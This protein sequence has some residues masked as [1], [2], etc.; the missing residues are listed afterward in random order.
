MRKIIFIVALTSFCLSN[1]Q[2]SSSNSNNAVEYNTTTRSVF[3]RPLAS[4]KV[5]ITEESVAG[6][7]YYKET[8]LMGSVYVKNKLLGKYK[9]R[10]NAYDDEVEVLQNGKTSALH[11]EEDITVNLDEYTF[12]IL[13]DNTNKKSYYVDFHEGKNTSLVLQPKIVLKK[14]VEPKNGFGGKMPATFDKEY[15]YF[16]KNIAGNLIPV[17]L[18][19]KEVLQI[20]S[21]KKSEIE[22]FASSNKLSF[23][24]ER[25][26]VKI[27]S[28]YNTL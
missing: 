6:S 14:P 25:D 28:H 3:L 24:K 10:Y 19:K 7:K 20:L 22:K 2:Q 1:A 13:R 8:F 4:S 26:L 9:V 23:K 27:V 17:K 5:T 15:K 21:N 12:K 18:K 16:I 11:Y